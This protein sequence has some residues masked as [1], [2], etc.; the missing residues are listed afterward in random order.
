MIQFFYWLN[1]LYTIIIYFSSYSVNIPQLY[2]SKWPVSE[3]VSNI[4]KQ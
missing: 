4:N 1:D 3:Y 2:Q